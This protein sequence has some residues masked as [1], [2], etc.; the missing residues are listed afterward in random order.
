MAINSRFK[1][2]VLTAIFLCG[3]SVLQAQTAGYFLDPNSE[4]PRFIQR[5]A[6]SGGA[7]SLHHEV[8]IEREDGGEY[9][10]LVSEF[11]TG[12]FIDISLPPG[13]YRFRVIPYDVL[14]KPVAGTEWVPFVVFNAVKP[15][16][17]QTE[18]LDYFNDKQGSKF[19]FNGRNIE[20]DAHVYFVNS[21]GEQITPVEVIRNYDGSSIRLVFNKGQLIDGKYEVFVVNPCGLETSLDGIDFKSYREK[22]GT[23]HYIVGVSFVPS[24]QAYGE[25]LSSG[26]LLYHLSVQA[27]VITCMFLDNYVGM[28]FTFSRFTKIDSYFFD[29]TSS[30]YTFGYNFIFIN[31]LPERKAAVKFK[32]GVV[33]DMQPM[34]LNY[35]NIGASFLYRFFKYLNIETG[36]NF[37]HSKK[38]N[39]GDILPW[40]GLSFFF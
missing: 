22:F 26:G 16:L 4:E 2:F 7:Y 11:T 17:Y 10:N 28:E 15:E 23:A 13:N 3:L 33:F 29:D 6:W 9:M 14:G 1:I 8:F 25:E 37:T 40:I 30:G 24:F 31:W 39:C 5:L 12:N 21:K 34:D 18:E 38:D 27:S 35:S 32:I 20:P 19:K 36:V